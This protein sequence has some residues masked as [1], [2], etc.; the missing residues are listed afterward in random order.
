MQVSIYICS[1]CF[2]FFV[3]FGIFDPTFLT[4]ALKRP[5]V[6]L[7]PLALITTPLHRSFL[8]LDLLWEGFLLNS[9]ATKIKD[10]G[11][12]PQEPAGDPPRF[13]GKLT[14]CSDH[15]I[16]IQARIRIDNLCRPK[17]PRVEDLNSV[18]VLLQRN[19]EAWRSDWRSIREVFARVVSPPL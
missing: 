11:T 7:L 12:Q 13:G 4:P 8:L 15:Q 6:L 19:I 2:F 3:T 5:P 10:Q 1:I 9:L 18:Q 14:N 17:H 16:A